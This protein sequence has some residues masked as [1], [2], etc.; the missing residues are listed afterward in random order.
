MGIFLPYLIALHHKGVYMRYPY[1]YFCVCAFLCPTFGEGI[2]GSFKG[3]CKGSMIIWAY[4][5]SFKGIYTWRIMGLSKWGY[6][7]LNWGYK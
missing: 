1:P 6:K 2:V 3:S 7:Y 5:G 4:K